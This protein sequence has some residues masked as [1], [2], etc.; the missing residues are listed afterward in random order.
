MSYTLDANI[1]LYAVNTDSQY[2]IQAKTFIESCAANDESWYFS[3]PVIHAFIRTSTHQ[4]IMIKPLAP[5]EATA[6]IDQFLQLPQVQIM[7]E[8]ELDFWDIY[9]KEIESAHLRGNQIPDAIIV[10]IMKSHGIRTIYTKDRDFL[11]FKD[12]KVIDPLT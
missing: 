3:W 1:L 4:K 10:S 2:H 7:G 9:R 12:I 5:R 8:N 6:F 11:C